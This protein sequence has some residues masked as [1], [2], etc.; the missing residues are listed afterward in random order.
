M[1]DVLYKN[2]NIPFTLPILDALSEQWSM[3]TF[4]GSTKRDGFYTA[5]EW[6]EFSHSNF[7]TIDI[8]IKYGK[9]LNVGAIINN[10]NLHWNLDL[11]KAIINIEIPPKTDMCRS[12]YEGDYNI[13]LQDWI[14]EEVGFIRNKTN[15]IKELKKHEY[16]KEVLYEELLKTYI[17]N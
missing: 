14:E 5:R 3:F 10:R 8:I 7:L 15:I 1:M 4:I 11:I 6:F 12:G 16:V 17:K 13:Y 9:F 2:K